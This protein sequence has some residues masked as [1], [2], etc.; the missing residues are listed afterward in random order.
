LS[1][2]PARAPR[3]VKAR[4][5]AAG[6]CGHFVA[7]SRARSDGVQQARECFFWVNCARQ[8]WRR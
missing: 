8:D 5:G 6:C 2:S 4:S 3:A 7:V 1:A